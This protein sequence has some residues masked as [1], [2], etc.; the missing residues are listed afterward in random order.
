MG[1][2]RR[3][4]ILGA[5]YAVPLLFV[6]SVSGC[7]HPSAPPPAASGPADGT[8]AAGVTHRA[9]P[10]SGGQGIDLV[11]VDLA[12]ASV[13]IGVATDGVKMVQ[14]S[15][16]GRAWTPHEWL[17]KTNALAAT[18]GGYFGAEVTPGRKEFVGLL[19]GGGRVRH[20]S[21]AL[22][23][24]GNATLKASRYVRSAFGVI[25]DGTPAIVWAATDAG[26]PQSLRAYTQ[27][28]GSKAG[29]GRAWRVQTAVGCGPMLIQGGRVVT[30]DRQERLVSAGP[31]PR[32][33]VAY[34][35]VT[36]RSTHFVL[37]MASGMEYRDLA[38]WLR[39]YFRRYDHTQAGAAMCL[40]GGAS[41]QLSY[42]QGGAVRSPRETGVTVP[43]AIVLLPR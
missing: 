38:E 27:P 19:V 20:A 28:T 8:L 23:G 33:F 29:T 31:E 21:P 13:K 24:H 41:T 37:G 42:R 17:D 7:R 36:G 14:G 12:R 16:T 3:D 35:G 40:D 30:T 34:D 5:R 18:N 2:V 26:R 6:L 10:T 15:V 1:D 39:D 9:I 43:D 25:R 32:T 11:D 22:K 4:L